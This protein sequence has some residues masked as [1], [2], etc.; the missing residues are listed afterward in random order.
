[1]KIEFTVAPNNE[2]IDLLTQKINE[3]ITDFGSSHPFCA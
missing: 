3:E 1:M 2:D